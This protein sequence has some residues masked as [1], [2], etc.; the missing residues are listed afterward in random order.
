MKCRIKKKKHFGGVFRNARH[1]ESLYFH[2]SD[3][4]HLVLLMSSLEL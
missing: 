4:V 3:H 2:Y 1:F